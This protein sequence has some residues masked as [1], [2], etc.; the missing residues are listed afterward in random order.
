MTAPGLVGKVTAANAKRGPAAPGAGFWTRERIRRARPLDIRRTGAP[1]GLRRPRGGPRSNETEISDTTTYPESTAGKVF[2]KMGHGLFE[3]SGTAVDSANASV[4]FT[5]GHCVHGE[6]R[7]GKWA[8]RFAFIPGFSEG[9]RPFGTFRSK[10]IWSTRPW[11]RHGDFSF[12]IGAAVMAPNRTGQRLVDVA[13]GRGIAFSQ[14][15][16]QSFQAYGYPAAG[17]FDGFELWRCDADFAGI[18]PTS[19][20]GPP[21][22]GIGCHLPE[23]AS[24]G[25]WIIGG[26][27]LDSVTSYGYTGF[28]DEIYGPYFGGEARRLFEK[29]AGQSE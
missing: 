29:V 16:E 2:M 27:Y 14:P 8:R 28:P 10:Q 17:G 1:R 11:V 6:G 21:D 23:G 5:A 3:C 24:G 20:P 15:R 19:G 13:G 4:V 18:D 9:Q 7:H 22:N 12:D 26:R 25:G